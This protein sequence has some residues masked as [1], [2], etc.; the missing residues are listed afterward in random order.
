[1]NPPIEGMKQRPYGEDYT[2]NAWF[3]CMLYSVNDADVVDA[4][5]NEIKID[6]KTVLTKN[7][8]QIAID[9]KAQIQKDVIVKWCDFVTLKI[10]GV[11]E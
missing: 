7:A 3:G 8:L 1:M 9:R 6:I 5:F 11:E 2:F 4:F 10:W